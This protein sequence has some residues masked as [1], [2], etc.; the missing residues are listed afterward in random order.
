M[1]SDRLKPKEQGE[2]LPVCTGELFRDDG[3][4]YRWQFFSAGCVF[5]LSAAPGKPVLNL[6]LQIKCD[7]TFGTLQDETCLWDVKQRPDIFA[8]GALCF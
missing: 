8:A 1:P 6:F 3:S 4:L 7:I 5:I 2:A